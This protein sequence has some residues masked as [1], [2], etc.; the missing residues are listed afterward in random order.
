M[1]TKFSL[2]PVARWDSETDASGR[3][4]LVMTW[5]VPDVDAAVSVLSSVTTER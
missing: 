4:R 1:D 5:E 2:R 3:R